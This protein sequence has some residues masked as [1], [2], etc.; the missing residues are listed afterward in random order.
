[1]RASFDLRLIG[2]ALARYTGEL[3]FVDVDPEA[4]ETTRRA[5]APYP[6]RCSFIQ[7]SIL[8]K[9]K[10]LAASGQTLD[11]ACTGGLFDYFPDSRV[12]YA[13]RL[14]YAMLKPGSQPFFTNISAR[15]PYA[16]PMKCLI[17]WD[18]LERSEDQV[19]RLC[20]E[21]GIPRAGVRIQREPAQLTLLVDVS[22]PQGS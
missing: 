22:K 12:V 15:H 6:C 8:P 17:E 16:V 20:E 11:F 2:P 3:V 4:L 9:L 21:A 1:M 10:E 19:L 5:L 18:V 14:L 7:G 13:L